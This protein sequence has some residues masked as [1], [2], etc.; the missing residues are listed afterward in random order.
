MFYANTRPRYLVSI[1][2]TIGPL[3]LYRNPVWKSVY[4]YPL[5]GICFTYFENILYILVFAYLLTASG[6]RF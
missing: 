3:V 6:N 4:L 1:Y 2:R 5:V